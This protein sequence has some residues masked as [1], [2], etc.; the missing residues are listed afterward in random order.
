M[1]A[2][3]D[4]ISF[5]TALTITA[6]A[7][8]TVFEIGYFSVVGLQFIS[9]VSI[10]DWLVRAAAV[11][12]VVALGYF[13]IDIYA[14]RL[15]PRVLAKTTSLTLVVGLP[16]LALVILT[17]V[18]VWRKIENADVYLDVVSIATFSFMLWISSVRL[19]HAITSKENVTGRWLYATLI[20]CMLVFP[21]A[22]FSARSGGA[23]C[24][25]AT[26]EMNY[27]A[28]YLRFVGAGHLV[29]RGDKTTFVP[30]DEMKNVSCASRNTDIGAS[31]ASPPIP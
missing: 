9:F 12:P 10:A 15:R 28:V 6:A 31:S 29:R 4:G 18:S 23:L 5:P 7:V 2:D 8:S 30:N 19:Q 26:K 25:I 24:S 17:L 22:R 20:L 13:L 1:Q 16:A 3:L 11:V 14:T 27:D 21:I